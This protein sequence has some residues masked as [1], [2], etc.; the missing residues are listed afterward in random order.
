[1]CRYHGILLCSD[2]RLI[3][4]DVIA[5]GAILNL[6]TSLAKDRQSLITHTRLGFGGPNL[7]ILMPGATR[8]RCLDSCLAS[9]LYI[10]PATTMVCPASPSVSFPC[11]LTSLAAQ[12]NPGH[13]AVYQNNAEEGCIR[14]VKS[15]LSVLLPLLRYIFV[16]HPTNQ[17]ILQFRLPL[18]FLYFIFDFVSYFTPP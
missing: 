2:P 9:T 8:R 13:Q 12:R 1:M 14:L 5:S 7:R 11:V 17:S 16:L 10:S 18:L 3:S 4:G 15:V 6:N